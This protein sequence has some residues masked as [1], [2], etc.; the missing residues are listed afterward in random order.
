MI[1]FYRHSGIVVQSD[2][3]VPEWDAFAA[4]RTAVPDVRLCLTDEIADA[5]EADSHGVWSDGAL[6]FSVEEE[7][8]WSIA[9]G[10]K[11]TVAPTDLARM[12]DARLFTLGSA[13]GALGYQRGWAMLHGSCVSL[14]GK[15]ALFCG[16]AEQG[17]STMAAAMIGHGA[18]LLADDLSRVDA[19][20]GKSPR[21][22][23]SSARIKLWDSAIASLRWQARDKKRDHFR[24][25]KY[26]FAIDIDTE[27]AKPRNLD[28]VFVLEWGDR[29][30]CD[31]LRGIDAVKALSEAS[32]Y[33][34]E[35]LDLMGCVSG[36]VVAATRIAAAIPIYRLTRPKDFALLSRLCDTITEHMREPQTA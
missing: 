13:W 24:D 29:I 35:F 16:D 14:D 31:R 32:M 23:P 3:P 11:I 4:E 27:H 34:R 33:R 2:F 36:H 15:T 12:D 7:G 10:S 9:G 28:A 6:T 1:H 17:K 30:A 21:I 8:V 18:Q 5:P 25:D 22:Y 26:H 19:G 20:E